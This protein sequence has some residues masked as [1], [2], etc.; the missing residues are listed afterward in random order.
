MKD[1]LDVMVEMGDDEYILR[2]MVFLSH[3]DMHF[4]AMYHDDGEMQCNSCMIDFLR[5]SPIDIHNK[6]KEVNERK[7]NEQCHLLSAGR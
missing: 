4:H 3:G 1:A 7:L 2:K 5:D 6:I